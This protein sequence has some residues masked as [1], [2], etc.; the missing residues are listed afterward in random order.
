MFGVK[1]Q[2]LAVSACLRTTNIPTSTAFDGI[3]LNQGLLTTRDTQLLSAL[4]LRVRA[5]SILQIQQTWWPTGSAQSRLKSLESRGWIRRISLLAHPDIKL[6]Q[7]L[8]SWQPDQNEPNFGKLSYQLKVR[9]T[10]P[11]IT[12]PTIIAQTKAANRFGGYG[13]RAPKRSETTHDLHLAGIYLHFLQTRPGEAENWSSEAQR[14]SQASRLKEKLP[15]AMIIRNNQS[16]LVIEM[17]GIYPAWRL[18]SFHQYCAER[19]YPYEIW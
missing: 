4:T 10:Q 6:N 3:S 15:D 5:L 17:G 9:W 12:T 14:A 18:E 16:P 8:A 2:S 7:P 11:L 19:Q 1:Q 13:D